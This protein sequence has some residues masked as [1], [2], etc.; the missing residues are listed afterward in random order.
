MKFVH[1]SSSSTFMAENQETGFFIIYLWILMG[2][3]INEYPESQRM[4]IILQMGT[5]EYPV[6]IPPKS[7]QS[8]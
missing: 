5:Q 8:K 3:I 2:I 6:A 1:T 4:M 7:A